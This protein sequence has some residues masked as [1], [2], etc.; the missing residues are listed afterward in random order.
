MKIFFLLSLVAGL[1]SAA[2][3]FPTL[4]FTADIAG[5]P[6]DTI[7]WSFSLTWDSP[8][9]WLSVTESAL[10]G[11]SNP[12]LGT[13]TDFIGPQGG[14][15]P[16]FA[17]APSTTWSE[18][19]D[20]TLMTGLGSYTIDP[21]AALLATDT[22]QITIFY[23]IFDASPIDGGN[24]L[25]SGSISADFSVEVGDDVA[26]PEPASWALAVIGLVMLGIGSWHVKRKAL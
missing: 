5:Q 13:Y 14:P 19:F 8:D 26:A 15:L 6:G 10:E 4:N 2:P 18:T 20:P 3:V 9:E 17:M 25:T 1:A 12:S 11:E 21:G 22:G 23:D 16:D 24:L 7:G